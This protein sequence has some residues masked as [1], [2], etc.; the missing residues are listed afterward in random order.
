MKIRLIPL[1]FA[2]VNNRRSLIYLGNLVDAIITI[3]ISSEAAG[4]TYL[5]SDGV[6]VSTAELIRRIARAL[7]RPAR[8]FS[9][10]T[11]IMQLAGK[12]LGKSATLDRLFGSLTV[13]ISKI[14][15]ELKWKTPYRMEDGLK[16]TAEWFKEQF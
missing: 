12:V 2:G 7:G 10:P 8:L 4:Q 14:R 15:H 5:V 13:D 1:P 16:E 6:D 9:F 3:C 11:S